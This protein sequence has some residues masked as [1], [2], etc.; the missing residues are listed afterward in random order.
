MVTPALPAPPRVPRFADPDD[1]WA[2]AAH[3]ED[4]DAFLMHWAGR[5][6]D[7]R[8]AHPPEILVHGSHPRERTFVYTPPGSSR[9]LAII[10]HGGYWSRFSPDDFSHLARGA[11]T[12]GWTV[13]MPGYPLCPDAS[14]SDICA[15][16]GRAIESTAHRVSGP[17]RLAG[18]SAGGHLVTHAS[19][20]HSTLDPAVAARL[21]SVLSISGV[22]DLVPLLQTGMNATLALDEATA[23]ALSPARLAPR[24]GTRAIAWVGADERPEFVRQNALLAAAWAPLGAEVATHVEPARHHF[25][26]IEDL[27]DA[28]SPMMQAWLGN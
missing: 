19:C 25:D 28:H 6:A 13:A 1:A 7:W 8:V 16:I 2:N 14:I 3:I 21:T 22:H 17:V 18:H 4:S 12:H 9:G 27:T 23:R 10:V 26:V 24:P 5:A 20:A 11:L 15:S